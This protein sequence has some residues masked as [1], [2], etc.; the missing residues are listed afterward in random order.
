LDI[1]KSKMMGTRNI[2]LDASVFLEQQKGCDDRLAHF[3]E[4][5]RYMHVATTSQKQTYK[6]KSG[7]SSFVQVAVASY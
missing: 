4:F 5:S 3:Y 6:K 2:Y 1:D 7:M